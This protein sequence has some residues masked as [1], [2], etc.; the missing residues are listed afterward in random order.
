MQAVSTSIYTDPYL[1]HKIFQ[2]YLNK[3]VG[4]TKPGDI[5]VEKI[6]KVNREYVKSGGGYN[7]GLKLSKDGT[8]IRP[9][10]APKISGRTRTK[11]TTKRVTKG[12][13]KTKK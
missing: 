11:E 12:R 4:S 13:S 5:T 1:R 6:K 8:V 9:T 2:K 7:F 3:K 10:N